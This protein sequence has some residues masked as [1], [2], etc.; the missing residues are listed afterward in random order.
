[1]D[2]VEAEVLDSFETQMES[3]PGVSPDLVQ[4]VHDLLSE[5]KL[6]KVEELVALFEAKSGVPLA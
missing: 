3:A 2:G 6:P 4:K 5:D 1:M